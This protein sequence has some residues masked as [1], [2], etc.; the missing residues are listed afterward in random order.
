[1]ERTII[2]LSPENFVTVAIL[3]AA[4]YL[5]VIGMKQGVAYAMKKTAKGG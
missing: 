4:A 3:S 5:G 2:G 1:M